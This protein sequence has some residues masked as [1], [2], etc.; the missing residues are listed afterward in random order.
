MGESE[1]SAARKKPNTWLA[2]AAF[3]IVYT[4]ACGGVG[5]TITVPEPAAP[6]SP[7]S[8]P[9]L[10]AASLPAPATSTV[11]PPCPE[12]ALCVV[13]ALPALCA[14]PAA[15]APLV[16][17]LPAELPESSPSLLQATIAVIANGTDKNIPSMLLRMV[18]R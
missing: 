6:A 17:P 5:G 1:P 3:D 7:S 13:P 12:P 10:P 9:A 11:P 4:P 8:V 18:P 2:S 15:C 14:P 16:P